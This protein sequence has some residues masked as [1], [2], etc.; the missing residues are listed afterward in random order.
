LKRKTQSLT[1]CK[2]MPPILA[3]MVRLPPSY[4]AASASRRRVCAASLLARESR[5]RSSPE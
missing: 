4:I 3:A 5:R 1:I 2:P